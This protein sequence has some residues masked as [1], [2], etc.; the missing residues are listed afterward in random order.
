MAFIL[1]KR[2]IAG[3]YRALNIQKKAFWFMVNIFFSIGWVFSF[4]GIDGYL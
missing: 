1:P 2:F 4:G 3:H